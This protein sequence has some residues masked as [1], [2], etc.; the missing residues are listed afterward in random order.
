V[1]VVGTGM[2]FCSIYVELLT[3]YINTGI[4]HIVSQHRVIF[5]AREIRVYR[6]QVKL[7]CV[8]L[9][10]F[11]HLFRKEILNLQSLEPLKCIKNIDKANIL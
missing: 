4:K 6:K 8:Y 1:D 5:L 11:C 3:K 9:R 7:S 10:W 2:I